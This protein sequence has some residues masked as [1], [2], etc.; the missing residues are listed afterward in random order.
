MDVWL[1]RL[2]VVAPF[3]CGCTVYRKKDCGGANSNNYG[4]KQSQM[5]TKISEVSKHN[6]SVLS[7]ILCFVYTLR[8]KCYDCI[9]F[10][11]FFRPTLNFTFMFGLL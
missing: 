9:N 8:H 6:E 10:F 1:H 4:T 7:L 2:C 11:V 3:M 5:F